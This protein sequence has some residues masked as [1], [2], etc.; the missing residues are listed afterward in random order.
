[1]Y[2]TS[3]SFHVDQASNFTFNNL[4][5]F[6]KDKGTET[7]FPESYLDYDDLIDD[8]TLVFNGNVT[9][10]STGW[11]QIDLDTP[12]TYDG[13]GRLSVMVVDFEGG[14]TGDGPLFTYQV[15]PGEPKDTLSYDGSQ[16]SPEA[17]DYLYDAPNNWYEM[18]FIRFGGDIGCSN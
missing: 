15:R 4:Q 5:I 12:F 13:D 14:A 10:N 2:I 1:M 7:A 18:H 11:Y 17:Q 9:F 16:Y 8:H 6:I 3:L